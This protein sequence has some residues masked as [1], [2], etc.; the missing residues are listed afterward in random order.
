M[1]SCVV[2]CIVLDFMH[3]KWM[4]SFVKNNRSLWEARLCI[5]EEIY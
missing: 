2:L 3:I 4:N 5:V 1:C